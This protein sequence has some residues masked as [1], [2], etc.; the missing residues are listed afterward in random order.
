MDA[1]AWA[2]TSSKV[3]PQA[4][5]ASAFS[6]PPR[7]MF[8]GTADDF[9]AWFTSASRMPRKEA[10]NLELW[11]AADI[12]HLAAAGDHAAE[13]T[14]AEIRKR[15]IPVFERV[16]GSDISDLR[17]KVRCLY[18][19]LLAVQIALHH[20]RVQQGAIGDL[21]VVDGSTGANES[22]G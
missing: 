22:D 20:N 15:C 11:G 21:L 8:L 6:T 1:S 5:S 10:L 18:V 7:A 12:A 13:K 16:V 19:Q 17:A 14:G 2:T 4:A 3:F 9:M